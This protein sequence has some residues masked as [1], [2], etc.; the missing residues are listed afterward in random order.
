[1]AYRE[2][3]HE[4]TYAK[5]DLSHF[6]DASTQAV[7]NLFQ[8]LA[9]QH[10]QK[11]KNVDQFNYDLTNGKFE[12]DQKILS[13]YA[14]NVVNR[15]K[16]EIL[17]NGKTSSETAGMMNQGKTWQQMSQIQFEKA[18]NLQAEVLARD[19]KDPYYDAQ[20]DLAKVK[21]ATNGKDNEVNFLD[22]GNRLAEAEKNLGGV[23]AFKYANYRADYVKNLGNAYKE[24]TVGN[25]NAT[26]TQYDQSTFWLPNGKP[27]VSDDHAI[28][29]IKSDPQGR[30]DAYFNKR[31]NDQLDSEISKMKAS[32]DTRV[33]WMKGMK[34][35]DIKN[36]LINDPSKNII[37]K[38]DFG[39]RK[40]ELAKADLSEAN[41][42]NS[43]ISVDY[44]A[45]KNDSQGLYKNENIV[46]SYSFNN[47]KMMAQFR[48]G[49][50]KIILP[51]ANGENSTNTYNPGPGGVL[52]QKNGKPLQ[53]TSN[54]PVSTD[55]NTGTT[56]KSKIGSRPFNLTSYQLQAFNKNGYPVTIQ[57]NSPDE[58][59]ESIK[60]LPNEHFDPNG[61]Y[62]LNPEMSIALQGYSV[63][64]AN[65]LNAANNQEQSIN[66][67]IAAA[68]ND[69]D[70]NEV[71]VQEKN[72]E[73]IQILKSMIQAGVDDQE[74][75][76][77]ASRAGIKGV[78][79]NEIVQA[80]DTDLGSVK[81]ITQGLDLKNPDYWNDGMRRV[82]EAYKAKAQDA[83]ASGYKSE[84]PKT[85]RKQKV[86]VS[87]EDFDTKWKSLKSGESLVGPDGKTYTKK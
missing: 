87:A 82:H 6:L 63:N 33:S 45:A 71:S 84:K 22:R 19:S 2:F 9:Q 43:K 70:D 42:I 3:H 29:Y 36:E 7:S 46:H 23:D 27:G 51:N 72:L 5:P 55:L 21:E 39:I 85:V 37:N 28:E 56:S 16:Q 8:S 75:S 44:K 65:I 32:G 20:V 12:N 17:N 1:M 67:K 38:Q 26:K 15:G 11:Q 40:R 31:V 48:T 41:R 13:E 25:P 77:A 66:S 81:A 80:T 49:E 58:M 69:N 10:R 86:N 68:Q 54:N 53:F 79:T 64:P 35:E 30:V 52:F 14:T 74:L 78:Q 24:K 57:G 18:K 73:K 47:D 60:K 34:D 62:K 4:K 83:A 59:I 50:N 76:L 61:S